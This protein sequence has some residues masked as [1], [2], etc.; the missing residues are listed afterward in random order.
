[1]YGS[2]S[3]RVR[4]IVECFPDISTSYVDHLHSHQEQSHQELYESPRSSRNPS[5]APST[6]AN[7]RQPIVASVESTSG[8][9]TEATPL[10]TASSTLSRHS[11][12]SQHHI[13]DTPIRPSQIHKPHYLASI[14]TNTPRH[15]RSSEYF[16]IINDINHHLNNGEYH[17]VGGKKSCVCVCVCPASSGHGQESSGHTKVVS[18][19]SE[20]EQYDH[21]SRP[22][23]HEHDH[24]PELT[25]KRQIVGIL[26]LQ[27]GIMIH[28]LVI[29]LTLAITSGAEFTTLTTAIIF[30]QLFEGLSLGIRIAAIPP[31]P[32][33]SLPLHSR[34]SSRSSS[35]FRKVIPGLNK[36]EEPKKSSWLQPLL[37]IL[38]AVT[39]PAG[40][41]LGILV[42]SATG[43]R[44]EAARMMLAQGLMSAISAGMLIYAATVEM[45]AADFVFGNVGGGGGHGH[46][47]GE[48]FM[49]DEDENQNTWKRKVLALVSLC[50]GV[51]GM[52][53]IGLGE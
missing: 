14:V 52:G 43:K 38:F 51:L 24:P 10:L 37:S 47:H 31:P 45:L 21:E 48:E 46:S 9:I 42:F 5:R 49:G 18:H 39:T 17:L 13:H 25:R 7:D 15:S 12:D 1:M 19:V 8:T 41:C 50:A 53:L 26:V 33:E 23:E 44:S 36:D 29:G 27:M 11:L 2:H 20:A 16:Y 32:P 28:S 35:F 22:E 3:L 4:I 34:S 6:N 30:H 40:M